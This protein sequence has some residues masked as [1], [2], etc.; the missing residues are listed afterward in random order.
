MDNAG[1]E[2]ADLRQHRRELR[3]ELARIRWWRRLIQARRDLTLAQMAG[4]TEP[5]ANLEAAWEALAADAPTAL[6]LHDVLWPSDGAP[7]ASGIERLDQVDARLD[8]YERRI[9]AN[10]EGVTAEMIDAMGAA[11]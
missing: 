2:V 4:A 8:S 6:E 5:D 9:S 3:R 1:A 11:R 10:L 7:T